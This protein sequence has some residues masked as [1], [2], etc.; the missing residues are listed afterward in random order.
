MPEAFKYL[1]PILV[2]QLTIQVVA[3]INLSK[4]Q[5][6]KFDNKK[7][8]VFIIIFGGIFGSIGYFAF[9]GEDDEYGSED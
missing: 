5:K 2:L 9:R 4:R 7:I 6:V 3:L 1:W 8:W